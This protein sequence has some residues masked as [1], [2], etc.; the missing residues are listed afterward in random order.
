MDLTDHVQNCCSRNWLA[1]HYTAGLKAYE[2]HAKVLAGLEGGGKQPS[3]IAKGHAKRFVFAPRQ[4]QRELILL[5]DVTG[6]S[7]ALLSMI[8]SRLTVLRLH[9]L[10]NSS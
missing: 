7:K 3:E 9:K 2:V 5:L 10:P 8:S 1:A 6:L 4:E